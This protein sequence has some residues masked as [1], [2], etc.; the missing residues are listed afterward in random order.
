[1]LHWL[2]R[3][4]DKSKA[5]MK[6]FASCLKSDWE[7]QDYPVKFRPNPAGA[8]LGRLQAPPWIVQIINWEVMSGMG[9][10]REEAYK[11]LEQRF[12]EYRTKH[13]LPRPGTKVPLQFASTVKIEQYKDIAVD[14][15]RKVLDIEYEDCFISD[16]SSLYDFHSEEDN[17]RFC[18]II[19][20]TYEVDVS[21]IADGNLAQ[22]FERI[23]N[24]RNTRS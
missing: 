16:Q 19:L 8:Q 15:C 7:L 6:L 5:L 10:T 11:Q 17:S 1:M 9:Q 23:H 14:F 21:D 2:D 20:N 4:A 13:R 22:I 3:R 18:K 24:Q 12:E